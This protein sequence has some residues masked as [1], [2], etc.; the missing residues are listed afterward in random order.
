MI[1][2]CLKTFFYRDSSLSFLITKHFSILASKKS[3]CEKNEIN[4]CRMFS[5]VVV[6]I[7]VVNDGINT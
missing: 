7:S 5:V 1:K 4:V 2:T 6:F 3:S